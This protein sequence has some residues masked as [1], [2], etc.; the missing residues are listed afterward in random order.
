MTDDAGQDSVDFASRLGGRLRAVR[1]QKRWSLHDMQ[2]AAGGEFSAAAVGSYERGER[3]ISVPRLNRLASLYKVRLE[4]LLPPEPAT[5]S[6]PRD[7]GGAGDRLVIDLTALDS[8][9]APDWEPVR[10]FSRAVQARRGDF[11]GRV[12]TIRAED[13]RSLALVCGHDVDELE[14][15]L[16]LT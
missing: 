1:V 12:L 16:G 15:V 3:L 7:G 9:T 6:E 14:R 4:E 10:R 8:L 2:V 13:A 5:A 11:N